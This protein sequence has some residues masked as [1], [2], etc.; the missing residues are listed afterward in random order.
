MASGEA[1]L[2]VPQLVLLNK[3]NYLKGFSL[4]KLEPFQGIHIGITK[5]TPVLQLSMIKHS[6]SIGYYTSLDTQRH[7]FIFVHMDVRRERD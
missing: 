7:L 2:V 4:L 3:T 5:Q 6:F 1:W